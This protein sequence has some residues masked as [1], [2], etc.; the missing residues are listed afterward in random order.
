M[1]EYY[2]KEYNEAEFEADMQRNNRLRFCFPDEINGKKILSIGSGPGVDIQF[3]TPGNEIH[4]MDISRKALDVAQA[5]GYI[6]HQFDLNANTPF[7]FEDG[8][9][10]IVVATDILEHIF[11]PLRVMLELRR[12]LNDK[13]EALLSVPNHFYFS[14]RVAMLFGKGIV[15]PF[16]NSNEWDY[17]HIR[18]FTLKEWE[19]FL[20][21]SGQVWIARKREAIR[22][23]LP[24]TLWIT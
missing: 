19:K 23:F 8:Y 6:V 12:V 20:D 3:L 9:F 7:P 10:D 17:F 24:D 15:L 13:G 22:Q 1:R 11:D 4:A 2:E 21:K 18:F 14:R 5:S 16:H